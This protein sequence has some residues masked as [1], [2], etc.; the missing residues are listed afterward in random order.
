M[1]DNA[2]REWRFYLDDM[3]GFADYLGVSL[4]VPVP[5]QRHKPAAGRIK[6]KDPEATSSKFAEYIPYWA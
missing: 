3:I 2:A 1:S 6:R 4:L 5:G